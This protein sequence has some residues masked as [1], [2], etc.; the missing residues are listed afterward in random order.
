MADTNTDVVDAQGGMGR[1][2]QYN[3]HLHHYRTVDSV[4]IPKEF[5]EKMHAQE[6]APRAVLRTVLG[7]PFPM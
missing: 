1:D 7:N 6:R 5:F 4:T 3:Q 2:T